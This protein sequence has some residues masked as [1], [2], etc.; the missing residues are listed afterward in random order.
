VFTR[1]D[2]GHI[3]NTSSAAGAASNDDESVERRGDAE[4]WIIAARYVPGRNK[5]NG[6]AYHFVATRSTAGSCY[7]AVAAPRYLRTV[8]LPRIS[9]QLAGYEIDAGAVSE[10]IAS[11]CTP[12]VAGEAAAPAANINA[13]RCWCTGVPPLAFLR[14]RIS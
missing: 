11:I 10:S 5:E 12:V 7:R 8:Q 13:E 2:T 1:F 4:L 3:G 14:R 9:N 6:R